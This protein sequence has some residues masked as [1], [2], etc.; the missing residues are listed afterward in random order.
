[1]QTQSTWFIN[2]R[3]LLRILL[4]VAATLLLFVVALYQIVIPRFEEIVLGRKRE[5]IRELTTSV[6]HVADRY[7]R[8]AAQ[9]RMSTAEAQRW[10]IAQVQNLRYG[11]EEK[12]YF[13]ITDFEPR[14]IVHPFRPDLNGRDLSDFRDSEGKRLFTEIVK[15]VRAHGDGFVDYTWQWK[16]DSSR[17]VP[18]LSYVKPFRPWG[19][20][21]G[22][23]IYIE[24]VRDEI[25]AL[26]SNVITISVWITVSIS[27]L[28]LFITVQ[29]LRAERQRQRAEHD[30]RESKEKYEALVEASTEGLLMVMDNRQLWFNRTLL[31]MLGYTEEEARA[32]DLSALFTDEVV[33]RVFDTNETEQIRSA[34][35]SH[36][37]TGLRRKDGS[38]IDVLLT[39]SPVGFYGKTGVVLIV[40][41]MSHHKLIA[42][43]LDESK[44]RFS[45]LTNRLALAVFR[46]EAGRAMRFVE[47]NAATVRLFGCAGLE[48]LQ[49]SDLRDYFE[50][51]QSFTALWDEVTQQGFV[52]NRIVRIRNRDHA[53]LLLS[54]SIA[55]VS[56]AAGRARYC[57]VLAEDVSEE[58]RS[59]EDAARLTADLQAP[60]SF[61]SQPVAPF[62]REAVFCRLDDTVGRIARLISPQHGSAVL[63]RDEAGR[64]V[65]MITGDELRGA[66]RADA[67]G[68]DTAAFEIMRAPVVTVRDTD[69]VHEVLNTFRDCACSAAAVRGAE[70]AIRGTVHATELERARLHTYDLFLL[71]LQRAETVEEVRTAHD[72]LRG[73]I[74][75]LIGGDAPLR[76][77]TYANTVLSDTVGKRL[78][79]IAVRELGPPPRPFVFMALGSE[80]R[81]E[82][83]LLTDQ[84]NAIAYAD[85]GGTGD[86]EAQR[87]FLSLGER[88]CGALD[89]VGYAFCKGEVMA[90]NPRWCQPLS[91]WK[92]YF[93]DWVRT[94]KPQDLLDVGIFFDFRRVCGDDELTT[95]LRAH[96]FSA[97]RGNTSV[98]LYMSQ[99]AIRVKP[100][101][102]QLKSEDRIDS[103][104][105]L[106]PIVDLARIYA[107][108]HD[109]R[110]TGTRERLA[111][112]YEKD[113][114][115]SVRYR[116]IEQAY[117]FL[118]TQ[119]LRRQAS[120]I[121]QNAAPDNH[122][123]THDLADVEKLVLRRVL[124]QIEEFQEKLNIDFKGTV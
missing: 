70:G 39:V 61:L 10:T 33:A 80:G 38:V 95:Q 109:V 25:A 69:V 124:A 5:M 2:R 45:A 74:R 30:L 65:G 58:K 31:G 23:G 116:D 75:V 112:L 104:W 27:L 1:M 90:Q 99:N 121:E 7:H 122:I 97:L 22:T 89:T 93:S 82:Q 37:E 114:F 77:I 98:F 64:H 20:I 55:M 42:D 41:D 13:W 115:S 11:E 57:D 85:Q 21:I 113:V 24:D 87:Y 117:I 18:K 14:M 86:E 110:A 84:D 102:R 76:V 56:D 9:G 51:A 3:F 43:A 111:R 83:T 52:T 101:T 68:A 16:D 107:L 78:I 106:L 62:I 92:Q 118:M 26:E 94:A 50:D 119:R 59:R 35:N 72:A 103:K 60:V 17:I 36:A 108:K 100:P 46:T 73:Y 71:R 96:L 28:L 34:L 8:E 29:N 91:T 53:P 15:T 6:W 54:I 81:G 123:E 40:K 12:D 49:K 66:L 44:Q 120:L 63:V 79:E 105:A 67:R 19:W 4:P 32:V 48:D 88:V 47:A